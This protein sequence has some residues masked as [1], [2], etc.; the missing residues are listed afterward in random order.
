M[1]RV[2]E[3]LVRSSFIISL[4]PRPCGGGVRAHGT[5]LIP[6]CEPCKTH[7]KTPCRACG[8][9]ALYEVHRTQEPEDIGEGKRRIVQIDDLDLAQDLA[10]PVK[11]FGVLAISGK[12]P[13]AEELAAAYDALEDYYRDVLESEDRVWQAH[14]R[15]LNAEIAG[16]AASYL[17]EDRDWLADTRPKKACDACG[18]MNVFNAVRCASSTCGAILDWEKARELGILTERQEDFALASG[19]LKPIGKAPIAPVGKTKQGEF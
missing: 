8:T 7:R 10:E 18:S 13:T 15:H 4:W 14:H 12:T 1:P 3:K 16:M 17:G 19:K 6:A 11:N 5:Y 2:L 9:Y